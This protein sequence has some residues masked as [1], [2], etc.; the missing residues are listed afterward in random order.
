MLEAADIYEALCQRH[1]AEKQEQLKNAR[2]AVAGLG[3]AGLPCEHC[4]GKTGNRLFE[5]NRL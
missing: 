2:I 4:T 5:A 3:G 1:T